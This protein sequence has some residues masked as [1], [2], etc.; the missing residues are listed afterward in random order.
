MIKKALKFSSLFIFLNTIILLNAFSQDLFHHNNE[1]LKRLKCVA[2]KK[3]GT[4]CL[5]KPS[6]E[7]IYCIV[8]LIQKKSD[9]SNITPDVNEELSNK[10]NFSENSISNENPSTSKLAS[11][12]KAKSA[13]AEIAAK[14]P[15]SVFQS[16]EQK[17]R[18]PNLQTLN[19]SEKKVNSTEIYEMSDDETYTPK[20]N[21]YNSEGELI[22]ESSSDDYTGIIICAL[23]ILVIIAIIIYLK[24]PTFSEHTDFK[25]DNNKK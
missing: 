2:Q 9:F 15:M 5:E 25:E 3:D 7:S 20:Y 13:L 11:Q 21:L 10:E 14:N 23:V 18:D 6:S 4:M 12:I 19:L 24:K 17:Q 16:K 8:H 1:L 22:E